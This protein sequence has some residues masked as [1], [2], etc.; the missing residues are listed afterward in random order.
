MRLKTLLL[1]AASMLSLKG[2]PLDIGV[3]LPELKGLNQDGKVV[4]IKAADGHAWLLIFTYPKALT[5]G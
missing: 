5:G 4:E 1:A 3:M 2:A